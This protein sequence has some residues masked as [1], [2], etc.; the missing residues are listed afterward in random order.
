MKRPSSETC[1]L[2]RSGESI[3]T[4][5]DAVVSLVENCLLMFLD[6]SLICFF[7]VFNHVNH[8][9]FHLHNNYGLGCDHYD[10][11]DVSLMTYYYQ[12]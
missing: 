12:R 3:P 5:H 8:V 1:E 11:I 2:I 10:G 9:S 6:S 7:G 4:F